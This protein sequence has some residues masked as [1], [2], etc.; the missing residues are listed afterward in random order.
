MCVCR[1]GTSQ[2]STCAE[3]SWM[4]VNKDKQTALSREKWMEGRTEG[5]RRVYREDREEDG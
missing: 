4:V 1:E 3:N 5:H 2:R